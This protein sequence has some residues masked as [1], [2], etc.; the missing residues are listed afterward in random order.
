MNIFSYVKTYLSNIE[1]SHISFLLYE[2]VY[3]KNKI[4]IVTYPNNGV[5]Q[6][7]LH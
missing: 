4:Y 6:D 2:K 1:N 7:T 3:Y 5:L